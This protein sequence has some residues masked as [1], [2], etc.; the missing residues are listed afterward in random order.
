MS[1][2]LSLAL[3][4]ALVPGVR[5]DGPAP[6]KVNYNRDILPILSDNCF[7]C[8][9]PDAKARKARLR[10]DVRDEAVK[11]KKVIVPGKAGESELILRLTHELPNKRMPP[12]KST[13]RLT[14][15]Q[16]ALVRKWV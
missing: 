9:G 8:H 3:A 4:L 16:I 10:L 12:E 5:A 7:A 6:E 2:Y 14:P 13:K 1:R 11:K 15:A